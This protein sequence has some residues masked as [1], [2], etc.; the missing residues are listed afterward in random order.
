VAGAVTLDRQRWLGHRWRRHGLDGHADGGVLDDLLL[1][2]VQGSGQAGAQQAIAVRTGVAGDAATA[3]TPTGPLVSL[4]SV[5]GAP[6]A[7]PV[8]RTGAVRQA[9]APQEWD[10]GG[11]ARVAAVEEVAAAFTAIVTGPTPKPEASTELTRRVDASLVAWC[12]PCQA[13][14]VPEPLFR[15][16][17]RQA[18]IVLGTAGRGT[19]LHPAPRHPQEA[20]DDP[21][22]ALVRTFVR[23]NGPTGRTQLRDWTGLGAEAVARS[24]RELG[25]LVRV[26]VDGRRL[27]APEDLVAEL[28]EAPPARGVVLVPPHDPYLAQA[29]RALLLPDRARRQEVWRAVSGPGALLVDGEVAGTWRYR[30]AAR[31]LTVTPFDGL[32][33]SR[34]KRVEEGARLVAAATGDD[35]P[36]VVRA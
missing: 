14:H 30:R 16:G 22:T 32:T 19:V 20:L 24:W 8:G 6:H 12:E 13:R 27:Q 10:D 31:E 28:R 1:L 34:R 29:D 7:H 18:G 11:S 26:E 25:A 17:G 9:W 2:G 21:R 4:W 23:V 3:V 5:R 33:A 36:A 15:D 35:A